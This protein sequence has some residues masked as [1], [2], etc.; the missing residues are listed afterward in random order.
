VPTSCS[1]VNYEIGCCVNNTLYW[2]DDFGDGYEGTCKGGT[3][4]G[5]DPNDDPPG[6]D[7]VASPGGADPSGEYPQYCP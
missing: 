7:C 4:C 1:Q 5:W 6:Y 2:C 3:V